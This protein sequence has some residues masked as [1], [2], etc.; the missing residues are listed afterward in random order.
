MTYL[1]LGL[2]SGRPLLFPVV[3]LSRRREG[4][5]GAM[6]QSI[7]RMLNQMENDI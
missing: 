6:I 1:S 2:F 5:G 7:G 4:G 3:D